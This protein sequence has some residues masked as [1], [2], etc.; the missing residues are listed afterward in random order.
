[1]AAVLIDMV[2]HN[3]CAIRVKDL[4]SEIVFFKPMANLEY[5]LI[6][7]YT[8]YDMLLAPGIW[9]PRTAPFCGLANMRS[10]SLPNYAGDQSFNWTLP[11]VPANRSGMRT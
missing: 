3:R 2:V 6:R 10:N 5:C 8:L 7:Q 1:M 9:P 4:V 11:D